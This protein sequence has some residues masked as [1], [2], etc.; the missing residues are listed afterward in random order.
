MLPSCPA[1]VYSIRFRS[2]FSTRHCIFMSSILRQCG[3]YEHNITSWLNGSTTAIRV[4][5]SIS[6]LCRKI[7]RGSKWNQTTRQSSEIAP[8]AA[9]K[10]GNRL[11]IYP[12]PSSSIRPFSRPSQRECFG[13]ECKLLPR[14]VVDNWQMVTNCTNTSSQFWKI[15]S[16]SPN[17]RFT[18]DYRV[19]LS[20]P[21]CWLSFR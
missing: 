16:K 15:A 21:F 3:F 19:A 4:R 17:V 13:F 6:Q 12:Q 8:A 10:S 14:S 5:M 1:Y 7:I 2:I 20:F 18:V 11:S 9:F